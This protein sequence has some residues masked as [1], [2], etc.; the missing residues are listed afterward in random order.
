VGD[1]H[2]VLTRLTLAFA[3]LLLSAGPASAGWQTARVLARDAAPH[4]A[5]PF[6][7]GGLAL[8]AGTRAAT[9]F[10][11]GAPQPLLALPFPAS[12]GT[13]WAANPRGDVVL[14]SQTLRRIQIDA[15]DASGTR[16]SASGRTGPDDEL[17]DVAVAIGADGSAVVAWTVAHPDDATNLDFVWV[18]VRAP[19]APFRPVVAVPTAGFTVDVDAGVRPDG[20]A[21]LAFDGN[22]AVFHIEIRPGEPIG[23]AVQVATLSDALQNLALVAGGPGRSRIMI[24]ETG[25]RTVLRGADGH[26]RSQQLSGDAWALG[27][28]LAGLADGGAVIAYGKESAVVVRRAAAGAPFGREE[29]VARVRSDWGDYTYSVTTGPGGDAMVAW[30]EASDEDDLRFG[31]VCGDSCHERVR[32]AVARRGEPFEPARV[33]SPLGTQTNQN[34]TLGLSATGE[35]LIAWQAQAG[36]VHEKDALVAVRG[37][38]SPDRAARDTRA[39]RL[40]VDISRA[41]LEAAARG[42]RLRGRVGCSEA[43]SVRINVLSN[44]D[45]A[46]LDLD[47]LPPIVRARPGTR[48][49]IWTLDRGQRRE[50]ARILRLGAVWLTGS[51]TDAAGNIRPLNR[52]VGQPPAGMTR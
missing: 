17:D 16:A 9:R 38:D 2:S 5:A 30:I 47:D 31:N 19:G 43:C 20:T 14:V 44:D 23:P 25:L 15:V 10:G 42:R 27:E 52:R 13:R 28:P 22:E 40:R 39:P 3:L 12:V 49:A 37:D 46:M 21:E 11:I 35:R 26:W 48:A 1:D 33:V 18:T 6:A 32:A 4:A 24:A 45:D 7:G 8:F 50:L 29:R 41:A 51:A 34:L 36:G